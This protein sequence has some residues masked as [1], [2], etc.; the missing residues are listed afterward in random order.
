MDTS[1]DG[2]ELK[3]SEALRAQAT[4]GGMP[5]AP[6]SAGVP[7]PGP[8]SGGPDPA[9][10]G[11]PAKLPVWRVLLFALLLGLAAGGLIGVLTL[12]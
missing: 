8:P 1:G 6:P 10:T 11:R 4:G 3:L 2:P 7:S 5:V 12:G 9:P